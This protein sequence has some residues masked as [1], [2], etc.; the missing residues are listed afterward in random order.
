MGIEIGIAAGNL[1]RYLD[2]RRDVGLYKDARA[3]LDPER[4]VVR[5]SEVE[6]LHPETPSSVLVRMPMPRRYRDMSGRWRQE[7]ALESKEP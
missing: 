1:K 2:L 3:L 7:D 5:A 6:V 4:S